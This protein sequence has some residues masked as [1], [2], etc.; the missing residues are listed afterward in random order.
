[1]NTTNLDPVT[2]P[3]SDQVLDPSSQGV[4]NNLT[5]RIPTPGE[6]GH[7]APHSPAK[8]AIKLTTPDSVKE[9]LGTLRQ[10]VILLQRVIQD[11][12][13][14]MPI[15]EDA[16]HNKYFEE[17]S[18]QDASKAKEKR[19]GMEKRAAMHR[20]VMINFQTFLR[21][22]LD[23]LAKTNLMS[24]LE[25]IE[26]ILAKRNFPKE[27]SSSPVKSSTLTSEETEGNEELDA[28]WEK[29]GQLAELKAK[30][31]LLTE[32]FAFVKEEEF[33]TGSFAEDYR[34]NDAIAFV[35]TFNSY[36]LADQSGD[37]E[38]T[39]R[40]AQQMS[41]LKKVSAAAADA[42]DK[43]K[44]QM[45]DIDFLPSIDKTDHELCRR[46]ILI[47]D[48]FDDNSALKQQVDKFRSLCLAIRRLNEIVTLERNFEHLRPSADRIRL[49]EKRLK[50]VASL[51]AEAEQ[52]DVGST[53]NAVR[54]MM[55]RAMHASEDIVKMFKV[56]E[57]TL[58]IFDA[59]INSKRETS[60]V[61]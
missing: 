4:Q 12:K 47:S 36:V 49:H 22:I 50:E 44:Q 45:T 26:K 37:T 13:Q 25:G 41:E 21:G 39:A 31:K 46:V 38:Q 34:G 17:L 51:K 57:E 28:A 6:A 55:L 14:H 56:V 18:Q 35:R 60:N 5:G 48:E 7:P 52:L 53:M 8:I 19:E 10:Y 27:M 16:D 15:F 29:F 43:I 3:L 1:M 32:K 40:K 54:E 11:S 9:T 24:E 2:R 30:L 33:V 20:E 61:L 59:T 23:E 42:L 58:K